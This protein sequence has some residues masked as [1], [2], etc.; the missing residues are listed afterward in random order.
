LELSRPG[1]GAALQ[2][3]SELSLADVPVGPIDVVAA[4]NLNLQRRGQ[5]TDRFSK[6]DDQLGEGTKLDVRLGAIYAL[7]QI[8]RDSPELHSPI[9][10]IL[11]AFIREHSRADSDIQSTRERPEGGQRGHGPWP[12]GQS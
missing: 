12:Q 6:A 1:Q 8:A 7:E 5:V 11:A 10:E 4:L 3:F 9:V 2:C